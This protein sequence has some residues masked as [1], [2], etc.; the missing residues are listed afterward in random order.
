MLYKMP[1]ALLR[2]DGKLVL[3]AGGDGGWDDPR[4]CVAGEGQYFMRPMA[5]P[6]P[7]LI[8]SSTCKC[9]FVAMLG[10]HPCLHH[11]PPPPLH[12]QGPRACCPGVESYRVGLQGM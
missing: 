3:G 6:H 7:L 10:A 2:Y 8:R 4:G 5:R 11:P 1:R 12:V 9:T